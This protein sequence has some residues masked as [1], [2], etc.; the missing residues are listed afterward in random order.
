MAA[1]LLVSDGVMNCV[2]V[3]L[4][5]R[6]DSRRG[7]ARQLAG[8]SASLNELPMPFGASGLGT[9]ASRNGYFLSL[10]NAFT[11]WSDV[12]GSG[13]SFSPR[14]RWLTAPLSGSAVES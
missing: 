3:Y 12:K 2:L 10:V 4:C 6:V 13:G 1:T 8:A 5:L 11:N 14:V 9:R 7:E